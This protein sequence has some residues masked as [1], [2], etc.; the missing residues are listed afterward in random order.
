MDTFFTLLKKSLVASVFIVFA[1]A[2]TYI[3]QDWN[4][5]QQ[6][7][8]WRATEFTQM[9]NNFQLGAVNVA[10][11]LSAGY[12]QITSWVSNNLWVKE[13]RLD[14]IAWAIAKQI[15]SSMVTSL[16]DW[17]NSGFKGRPVFVQDFLGFLREAAD[18]AVGE[19]IQGLGEIGSF[20]CE[21]FRLDIQIAIAT[22][23]QRS[24]INQPAP[25][26]TLTGVL[27]NIKDFTSGAMGSFDQGGWE[28]WFDI[29][30][31]PE[32]YTPYGAYLAAEAGAQIRILN[33]KQ[34]ELEMLNWGDGFLSSQICETVHGAG[35]TKEQ[36]FI[37]T[38]GKVIQE[39]LS[40]NLDSGRQSLIAAD[41]IDEIIGALIGQ[42]ANTA[43]QGAAGLLGLSGGTGYTYS[44]FTGNSYTAAVTS[45][46]TNL[47]AGT[48]PSA[49]EFNTMIINASTTQ[50]EYRTL[51]VNYRP[52]LVAY[53]DNTF[54]GAADRAEAQQAVADI[55]S[56]II[57]QTTNNIT[58]LDSLLASGVSAESVAQFYSLRLFTQLDI[59]NSRAV[60]NNILR[61][62][63][64]P[65][66]DSNDYIDYDD[67]NGE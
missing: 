11:T 29:T 14:G 42:L 28:A 48:L 45:E 7:H 22:Q 47:V 27:T 65:I 51:A 17:I 41:E 44:G 16:V 62:N 36:C 55:D 38:P 10:T 54:N 9:M 61:L 21:P 23:Y 64:T 4:R 32:V 35:T 19:Y 3:P 52:L 8:A 37:S 50:H 25:T 12:A 53:A 20:I 13:Y 56:R 58:I 59:N 2:A 43:I 46:N 33:S 57:P 24:R 6:A 67:N 49:S 31:Q 34:K 66:V 15:V 39:A 5:V 60:W 18:R 26:C 1:V 30:S 63:T 40:F